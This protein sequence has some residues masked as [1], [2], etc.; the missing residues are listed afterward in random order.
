MNTAQVSIELVLAGILALCAF[1]LPF[2]KGTELSPSLLQTDALIGILGLAY[3]LGVVFD[4]LADTIL[5]PM[6]NYLRLLQADKILKGRNKTRSKD[7][8][9]QNKLEYQLRSTKDGRLDW[10]NS[11]KSRIRTSR[12]L[13]VLGLPASMGIA[14][15]TGYTRGCAQAGSS[16][17]ASQWIYLFVLVN[18]ILFVAAAWME[19][20]TP[21]EEATSGRGTRIKT[22][23]LDAD[24]KIRAGQL[25]LAERQMQ[26]DS[27][28]YYLMTLN[29]VIAIAFIAF[30]N[31][32]N[33]W[34]ALFGVGGLLFSLLSLWA[35]LRITRTYMKF[36]ARAAATSPSQPPD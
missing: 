21:D 17:C 25:K 1:V 4:K 5:S 20:R 36:V 15:Y 11:L 30:I 6:E 13:A 14:I 3:L 22:V 18:L 9:P 31:P 29:C 35:C 19:S 12:E 28:I 24:P 16:F 23:D 10:M 34:I 26:A 8:F 2:W 32:G 7:A 27:R 33:L